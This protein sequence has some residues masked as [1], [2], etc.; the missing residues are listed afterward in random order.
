[1]NK[2]MNLIGIRSRMATR[3]K[4][5][6]DTKNKVL[7]LYSKLIKKEKLSIFKENI[8]DLKFSGEKGLKGNLVNRLKIDETK[9]EIIKNSINKI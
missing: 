4:I 9:L 6:T 7:N 5:N 1:M 8:K 2:L 3:Q